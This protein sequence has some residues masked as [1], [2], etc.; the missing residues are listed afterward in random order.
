MKKYMNLSRIFAGIIL[1][2]GLASCEKPPGK[3]GK[4]TVQGKLWGTDFDNTQRY[5]ISRGYVAGERVYIIYGNS[6]VVGDDMRTSHD[7][8]YEFKYLTK[9]HYKVY[10]LSLD[11]TEY[12]KGRDMTYPVM[13]EFDIT[14]PNQ[15]VTLEDLKI[16]F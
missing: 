3:G 11:T 13:I 10:A 15:V 16:N 14:E 6:N 1:I 4:A 9:G 2:A 7:G 8:S 12:F 5:P